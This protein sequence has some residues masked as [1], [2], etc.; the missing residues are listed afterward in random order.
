MCAHELHKSL[1][2]LLDTCV[3]FPDTSNTY[4]TPNSVTVNI[5]AVGAWCLK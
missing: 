4:T 1:A 5:P 3:I 2:V